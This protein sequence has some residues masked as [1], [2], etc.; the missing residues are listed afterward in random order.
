[1]RKIALL[2]ILLVLVGVSAFAE[3]PANYVV[4]KLGGYLPQANDVEDF[5]NSF[6]GELAYGRYFHPNIAA[7]FG[8]GYTKS[9]GSGPADGVDLTIMPF[10]AAVKGVLPMG[11]FEPFATL[12]LG[13]FWAKAEGTDLVGSFDETDTVFG[14]FAGLGANYNFTGNMFLG[15]E[16]RYFFAEPSF[17]TEDV[18]IDGINLTANLGFRF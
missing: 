15:V 5:D 3:T 2:S 18:K 1:M 17:G 9:S 4:L 14:Y 8:I 7:E 11:N 10:T 12:G 6:Y 13:A 16:G